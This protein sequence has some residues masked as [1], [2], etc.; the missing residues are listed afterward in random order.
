M[1]SKKGYHVGYGKPPRHSQFKKGASGNKKG[2]PK[3]SK[4]FASL[5]ESELAKQITITENG[6]RKR[7]SKREGIVKQIINKAV[8]GEAKAVQVVME[9]VERLDEFT[10]HDSEQVIRTTLNIFEKPL[11]PPNKTKANSFRVMNAGDAQ[12]PPGDVSE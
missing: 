5:F 11:T 3:G 9:M 4:N 2:R 8:A 7:I 1:L 12:Q 10:I 6:Q